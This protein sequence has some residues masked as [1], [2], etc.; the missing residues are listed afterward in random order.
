MSNLPI[1]M[2]AMTY[3]ATLFTG[4]DGHRDAVSCLCH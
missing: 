3:V 4:V 1:V 2:V